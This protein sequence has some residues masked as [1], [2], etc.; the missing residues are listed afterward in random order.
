MC[1]AF[2]FRMV[3]IRIP[4]AGV[5]LTGSRIIILLKRPALT[6]NPA[7]R[8]SF[9]EAYFYVETTALYLPGDLNK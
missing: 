1:A 5:S 9:G 8:L 6:V 3:K 2:L 4:P 7:G